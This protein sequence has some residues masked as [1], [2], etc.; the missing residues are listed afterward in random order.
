MA[1]PNQDN[2]QP[3]DFTAVLEI[4]KELTRKSASGNYIYRGERMPYPKVTSSLYRLYEDIEAEHFDIEVVQTEILAQARWYTRYTGEVNDF[5]ILSQLQHN[6]GATNL[7]DFTKDYL[8]ALFFA[9][10]GEP[11][12]AGRVILLSETGAAYEVEEPRSPVHRVIAQKSVFVRPN[13]GFVEPDSMVTIDSTLKPTVL[14]YL[15]SHHDIST[16][17]IY[18]DLHGFIR[19]QGIHQSAYTEFH[20]AS[21]AGSNGDYQEAISHYTNALYLNP[22]SPAAYNNRGNMY[23][24]LGN[25][26]LAISDYE[27]ALGLNPRKRPSIL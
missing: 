19:H 17:T 25:Y 2:P 12:K 13:A 27:A 6:G 3:R 5:E 9:C 22:Q 4:I 11:T 23:A 1:M 14:E 7:I 10:D 20:K 26:R 18:N 24:A 8:I 21:T 16:E 15:R